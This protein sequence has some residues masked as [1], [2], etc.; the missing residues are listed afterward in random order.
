MINLIDI[1]REIEK[2]IDLEDIDN[3]PAGKYVYDNYPR[4][5]LTKHILL[6]SVE[7]NINENIQLL[8]YVN[9]NYQFVIRNTRCRFRV[10]APTNNIIDYAYSIL[11]LRNFITREEYSLLCFYLQND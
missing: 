2:I 9:C 7:F 6:A 4:L 10:I 8:F 5:F 11:Y 1:K 3:S